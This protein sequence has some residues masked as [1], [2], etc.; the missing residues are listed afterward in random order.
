MSDFDFDAKVREL[1][2]ARSKHDAAQ[3]AIDGIRGEALEAAMESPAYV[4]AEDARA[5][6]GVEAAALE[7]LLREMALVH[8]ATTQ[9]KHPHPAA[10]IQVRVKYVYAPERALGWCKDQLS[11]AVKVVQSVDAKMFEG[12]IKKL[13]KCGSLPDFVTVEETPTATISTDLAGYLK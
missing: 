2:A 5:K 3:K 12:V 9:D 1:A 6:W 10:N 8:F 11:A 13:H 4:E 7:A